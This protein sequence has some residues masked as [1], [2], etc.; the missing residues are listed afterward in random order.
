MSRFNLVEYLDHMQEAATLACGYV[1]GLSDRSG[2]G[3]GLDD[4]MDS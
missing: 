2:G 3:V 1:V 4:P